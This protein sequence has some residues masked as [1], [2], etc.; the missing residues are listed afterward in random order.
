MTV[1]IVCNKHS[2]SIV[3]NEFYHITWNL[4]HNWF[5]FFLFYYSSWSEVSK[6]IKRVIQAIIGDEF[7]L[8]LSP[9]ISCCVTTLH[10]SFPEKEYG[11]FVGAIV[12]SPPVDQCFLY[13]AATIN[14]KGCLCLDHLQR[15]MN[16]FS[17]IAKEHN[18]YWRSRDQRLY[19][20][21]FLVEA[22]LGYF[23]DLK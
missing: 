21:K 11:F 20:M 2:E 19:E 12:S 10:I 22:R 5:M 7:I 3:K 17:C 9:N 13:E 23:S 4:E 1:P 16:I 6:I 15:C 18:E 8:T 14:V